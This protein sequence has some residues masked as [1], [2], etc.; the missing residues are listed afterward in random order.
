MQVVRLCDTRLQRSTICIGIALFVIEVIDNVALFR[1]LIPRVVLQALVQSTSNILDDK[2]DSSWTDLATETKK[3]EV[4]T[5][6]IHSLE[7]SAE[8][9]AEALEQPMTVTSETTNIR[10]L[11]KTTG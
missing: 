10:E 2:Q 3:T 8:E 5:T 7:K 6:I 1:C 4:A 9:V 11:K